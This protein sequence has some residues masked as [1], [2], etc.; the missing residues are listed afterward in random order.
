MDTAPPQKRPKSSS[1]FPADEEQQ[2][3]RILTAFYRAAHANEHHYTMTPPNSP[4]TLVPP[5][6][7]F[8]LSPQYQT[9]GMP[10]TPKTPPN[11]PI[12][13]TTPGLMTVGLGRDPQH[14]KT[15]KM[16][17]EKVGMDVLLMDQSLLKHFGS[18]QE[19]NNMVRKRLMHE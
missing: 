10:G 8:M 18:E 13:P 9:G 11:T 2:T 6:N 5:P 15:L 19:W 17:L 1:P 7:A 14:Y 12:T 4:A 16:A 3:L